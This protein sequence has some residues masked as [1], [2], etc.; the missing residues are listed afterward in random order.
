MARLEAVRHVPADWRKAD[1]RR[2]SAWAR[3]AAQ[4]QAAGV[5]GGQV[6]IGSIDPGRAPGYALWT[7]GALTY[8]SVEPPACARID[9]CVCEAGRL[10]KAG[11]LQMWG[12]GFGAAWRLAHVP[13]VDKR[14][15]TPAQWRAVFG[16]PPGMPGDVVVARLRQRYER[17]FGSTWPM[18]DWTDDV[19]EA[20]GIGEAVSIMT[21]AQRGKLR[22]VTA[23]GPAPAARKTRRAP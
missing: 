22:R 17:A 19:V 7:D 10:G 16:W 20:V 14:V 2:R 13:A 5:A 3:G 11:K 23:N 4:T 6:I 21:P 18:A 8:A 1:A 9:L 12:L 15:A